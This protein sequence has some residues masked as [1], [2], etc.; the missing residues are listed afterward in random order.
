M[1]QAN[2]RLTKVKHKD[3]E[4]KFFH[5]KVHGAKSVVAQYESDSKEQL[6]DQADNTKPLK[7]FQ[8]SEWNSALRII[9]LLIFVGIEFLDEDEASHKVNDVD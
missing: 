9:F 2:N 7:L 8:S 4:H 6:K 1:K 3:C 5:E